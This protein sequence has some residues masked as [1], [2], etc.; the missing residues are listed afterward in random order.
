MGSSAAFLIASSPNVAR[1]ILTRDANFPSR[2][3][4]GPVQY[5][6][7]QGT[8]FIVA[9]Y[10]P[11]YKFI[12]KLCVTKLFAGSQ[13]DRFGH[14]REYEIQA[15]LRSVSESSAK[16]DACN[17]SEKLS[18]LTNNLIFRMIM[19][20]RYERYADSEVKKIREL[21]VEIM[22]LGAKC[23]IYEVFG[24]LRKYDLFGHG[25]RLRAAM[26]RYDN[27]LEKIL[28]D[29]EDDDGDC[30][31]YGDDLINILLKTSRDVDAEVKLTRNHIKHFI[32]VSNTLL[33]VHE[34]SNLCMIR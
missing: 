4:L 27:L 18:V 21:V 8:G 24:P 28:G 34:A 3:D 1:Q 19:E 17:L 31:G 22:E 33:Y 15:C 9:P 14:I 13:L 29:Y 6:I 30:D 23:G 20:K 16:R 25:R 5:S 26:V 10:G 12:K 32:L 7:Y 11:Y 2:F